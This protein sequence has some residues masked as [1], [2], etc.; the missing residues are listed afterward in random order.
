MIIIRILTFLE[1]LQT[2]IIELSETS[3]VDN[4]DN[5]IFSKHPKLTIAT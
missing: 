4:T 2:G 5:N 3:P 1:Y